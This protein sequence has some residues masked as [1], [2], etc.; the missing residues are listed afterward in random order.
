MPGQLPD[1]LL[2]HHSGRTEHA[3]VDSLGLHDLLPVKKKPT[4]LWKGR[5]V[6]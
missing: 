5:R 4:A 2:S 1:E 6:L 3:H